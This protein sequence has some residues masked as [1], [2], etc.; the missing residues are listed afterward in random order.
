LVGYVGLDI[1]LSYVYLVT[2]ARLG[3]LSCNC[4]FCI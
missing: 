2:N 3:D 1:I 4:F